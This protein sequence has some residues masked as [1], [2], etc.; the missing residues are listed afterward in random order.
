M[1]IEHALKTNG[2]MSENELTYIASLAAKHRF[3]VELGS[4]R[5]RSAVAWAE[6][7]SGFVYCVD[8][9][10]DDAYGITFPDDPPDL[11]QHR[12]WLWN[13]FVKNTQGLGNIFPV[14][15]YTV[16][17]AEMF[18]IRGLRPDVIFVDADHSRQSVT[19]D[20]DAWLPLLADGGV[21]CGH[22]YGYGGWPDVDVVVNE[23]VAAGRL[24]PIRLIDTLWTCEP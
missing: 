4:W 2:W 21:I 18:R 15:A 20:L 6:N 19:Q 22:D 11:H 7:T 17:A 23:Y 1:N 24:K 9:W 10:R 12:D 5:G 16:Q 14:R 8:V 13:L 3:I